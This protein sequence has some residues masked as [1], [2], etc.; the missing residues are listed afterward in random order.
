MT[1]RGVG[2]RRSVGAKI[3]EAAAVL[4]SRRAQGL[5]DHIEDPATLDL[6]RQ[7]ER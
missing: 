4:V 2:W 7:N 5:P 3:N 6:I 1:A